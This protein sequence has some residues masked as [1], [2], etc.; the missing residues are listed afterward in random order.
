ML[1]GESTQRSRRPDCQER[2]VEARVKTRVKKREEGAPF[3]FPRVTPRSWASL[4]IIRTRLS[5]RNSAT[6]DSVW[7]KT[8][9]YPF[10]SGSLHR[11]SEF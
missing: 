5:E 7:S 4:R 1:F 9:F 10:D 6:K 2:V 11:N 8:F 3:I